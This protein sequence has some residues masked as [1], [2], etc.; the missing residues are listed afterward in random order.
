[1]KNWN[2]AMTTLFAAAAA[3]FLLWLAAQFNMHNTGGYWAALGVVAGCG[4]L[5]GLAQLRGSGGN[6]PAMLLLDFV[7]VLVCAGWIL[8][9]A[10]P[11]SNWFRDHVSRWSGDIG[12]GGVVHDV[13]T[14][15]G[16]LAFGIGLVFGY[17]LEPR[18][19][20]RRREAVATAPVMRRRRLPVFHRAAANEPMA[21]EREE[22]AV[23]AERAADRDT[24]T[25]K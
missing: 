11:R 25:V 17:M 22:A 5:L 9:Y 3:G 24:T 8:V 12:I 21:A 4:L 23:A 20:A 15:N 16:V 1:M 18:M 6:P 13:A 14:F 2:R 10:E 7:P 19:L